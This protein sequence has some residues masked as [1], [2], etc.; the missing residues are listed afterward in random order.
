MAVM[1]SRDESR[2][3][4]L[5]VSVSKASGL[6]SVSVSR[7]SGLETLNI[8]KKWFLKIPITQIFVFV[9]FAG[10]KQPKHDDGKM[11]QI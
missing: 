2:G 1:E 8:A 11:L 5:R 7:V 10:K 9:V 3:P 4:F 6:V